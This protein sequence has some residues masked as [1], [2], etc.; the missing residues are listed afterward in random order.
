VD[1]FLWEVNLKMADHF[2]AMLSPTADGGVI[3]ILQQFP[4]LVK[5]AF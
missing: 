5:Y 3:N 4:T 2:A 1:D